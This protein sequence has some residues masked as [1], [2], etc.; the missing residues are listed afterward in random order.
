[1][2]VM[3][4]MAS[5]RS[6]PLELRHVTKP[7][8]G[9]LVSGITGIAR[10]SGVTRVS[11]ITR[12]APVWP[13]G[14]LLEEAIAVLHRA[15]VLAV[16]VYGFV[17]A[18]RKPPNPVAIGVEQEAI[19]RI[20]AEGNPVAG[21]VEKMLSHGQLLLRWHLTKHA[22]GVAIRLRSLEALRSFSAF[23]ATDD[24]QPQTTRAGSV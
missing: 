6:G 10:V 3:C 22:Q 21:R 7:E 13:E 24:R 9:H 17:I 1:M 23:S 11:R 15:K 4:P 12:V 5:F 18:P 14:V 19:A 2:G 16:G 8:R 20:A